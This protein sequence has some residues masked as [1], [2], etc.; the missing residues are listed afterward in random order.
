M[1]SFVETVL[2]GNKHLDLESVKTLTVPRGE[3]CST[4]VSF[5][6]L[7]SYFWGFS[8]GPRV[9][10]LDEV[11]VHKSFV[12]APYPLNS[13]LVKPIERLSIR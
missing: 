4:R 11:S 13:F 10:L 1:S 8:G 2:T 5:W 3:T 7:I 9:E 12:L 6:I